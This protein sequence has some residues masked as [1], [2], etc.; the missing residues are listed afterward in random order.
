MN[1]KQNYDVVNMPP[2]H[3]MILRSDGGGKYTYIARAPV[4]ER[5]SSPS[6]F[7][8]VMRCVGRGLL[9]GCY[10]IPHR[11]GS[12]PGSTVVRMWREE[13]RIIV[14]SYIQQNNKFGCWLPSDVRMLHKLVTKKKCRNS[15][16]LRLSPACSLLDSDFGEEDRSCTGAYSVSEKQ[17]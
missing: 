4:S 6:T 2:Q 8:Q 9:G 16:K 13:Q 10:W 1:V 12:Y 14:L 3:V 5:S 7:L 17:D 11:R 15:A